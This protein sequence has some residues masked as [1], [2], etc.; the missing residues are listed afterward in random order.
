MSNSRMV[1]LFL[2]GTIA[3]GSEKPDNRLGELVARY[4][5]F[6]EKNFI[7]EL[8]VNCKE[9]EEIIKYHVPGPG[10]DVCS[11]KVPGLTVAKLLNTIRGCIDGYIGLH[12][13]WNNLEEI[14]K[15]LREQANLAKEK[16]QKIVLG[17]YTYSRGGSLG[18]HVEAWLR[19]DKNMLEIIKKVDRFNI[20][21]VAGGPF[22]RMR[23]CW[24]IYL[25]SLWYSSNKTSNLDVL[26]HTVHSVD[27]NLHYWPTWWPFTKFN[28]IF[29]S[30]ID[31]QDNS[32]SVN[33]N[34]EEIAGLHKNGI[35]HQANVVIAHIVNSSQIEFEASWKEKI[36]KDGD[37]SLKFL[38]ESTDPKEYLPRNNRKFLSTK[39][40]R[41]CL[42]G[43]VKYS[44][45]ITEVEIK[46]NILCKN[47]IIEIEK[48]SEN[49]R[50]LA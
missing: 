12:G 11:N 37:E 15:L 42:F 47:E 26:S 27:G 17:M 22:D 34:H 40:L 35:N 30:G 10:T 19:N 49:N 25:Y 43:D 8:F 44:P 9:S 18:D 38:K 16:N 6:N 24:Y 2:N 4:I 32:H 13:I 29:F 3:I 28:T 1:V 14:Q 36:L 45:P 23:R 21:P 48:T 46:K 31:Y 39:S 50:K 41:S 20:D 7:W 33:L 5:M